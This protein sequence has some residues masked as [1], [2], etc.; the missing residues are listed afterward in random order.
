MIKAFF[1]RDAIQGYLMIAPNSI[2]LIAFYVFPILASIMLGLFQWN[3]LS[4]PTWTGFGN[5]SAIFQDE[6]F[7]HSLKNT[8]VYTLLVVPAIVILTVLFAVLLTNR[9]SKW[10]K[11]MRLLYLLPIMTIPAAAALIWKWMLNYEFGLINNILRF[12]HINPLPWLSSPDYILISV[13]LIGI[14]L[15]F[16]FNLI[17]MISGLRG[18]PETYYEAAIV[19][20]ANIFQR[21]T[22]IT[23][24]LLTP[25]L[26]FVIVT[27]LISC[28]QV[29]DTAFIILGVSP[30]GVLKKAANTL[31]ISIYENGFIFFKMGYSSAQAFILF[32]IILFVTIVQFKGQ[33]KWVHY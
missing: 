24:P 21:F 12:I 13:M 10:Y 5:F 8:L 4:T 29:F 16:S 6:I 23:L 7:F 31:V 15:G 3:G 32:L 28:F 9:Q 25:T 19:D 27:Q 14:W 1:R 20:G 26:F 33:K 11:Y 18:I 17:I 30:S 22:G 2:G